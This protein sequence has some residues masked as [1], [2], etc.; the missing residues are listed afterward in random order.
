MRLMTVTERAELARTINEDNQNEIAERLQEGKVVDCEIRMSIAEYI[1]RRA[2]E[3][4]IT[5]YSLATAIGKPS[6]NLYAW[7]SGRST[8]PLSDIERM[9][10]ILDG[11]ALIDEDNTRIIKQ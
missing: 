2:K 7:M 8:Y 3:E 9:L 10:W 11:K 4:G 5:V 6:C 1:R